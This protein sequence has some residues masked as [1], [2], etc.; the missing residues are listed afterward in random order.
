M[1]TETEWDELTARAKAYAEFTR[2]TTCCDCRGIIY[3]WQPKLHSG[4]RFYH[5]ETCSPAQ[6]G[7][8]DGTN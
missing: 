3:S 7:G 1:V 5:A 4:D 8:T 6:D 2:R